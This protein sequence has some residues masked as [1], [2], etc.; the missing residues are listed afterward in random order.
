MPPTKTESA[1]DALAH[2]D[3]LRTHG[4]LARGRQRIEKALSL[5]CPQ[6]AAAPGVYCLPSV[7]GFCRYRYE[8]GQAL[9]VPPQVPRGVPIPPLALPETR[10]EPDRRHPN[11]H[12][13]RSVR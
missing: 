9:S 11:R 2:Q 4:S 8:K 13:V 12:P 5:P 3:A 7:N 10:T 1:R 6:C